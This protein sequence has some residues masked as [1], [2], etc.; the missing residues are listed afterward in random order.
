MGPHGDDICYAS[1]NRQNAVKELAR[2]NELVLIVGSPNSSNSIRMVEVAR[3][4]GARSHLVPDAGHLD[5]SWLQG[6]S[7]VGISSGASAPELLVREL[8]E[9]LAE[10]GYGDVEVARGVTEDLVFAMPARLTD[11]VTGRIPSTPLAEETL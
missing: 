9:K 3:D 4:R 6:V 8:V 2:A 10:L 7:S 1:Q 11:P 5:E